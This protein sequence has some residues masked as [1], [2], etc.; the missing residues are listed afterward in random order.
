MT[1]TPTGTQAATYSGIVITVSDGKLKSS[2]GVFSIQVNNP[3]PTIGGTPAPSVQANSPY[4][5]IPEASDPNNDKLTFS[6]AKK[7]VWATFNTT[8]GALTGTPPSAKAGLYS[9][10]IITVSDGK[11]KINL[12]VFSIQVN[13][14]APTISGTAP[15]SLIVN[16]TYSFTPTASDANGDKLTFSITNKPAW[17]TFSTTT[18]ALTGKPLAKHVGITKGISIAVTDGK[19]KVSLSAFDLQVSL[20]APIQRL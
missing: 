6:I 8:T 19:T 9:G 10:I 16:T 12:P 2:L 14:P 4:S 1:G 17:A 15:T 13:N 5:F 11:T 3:A 18:G 7:P 20:T